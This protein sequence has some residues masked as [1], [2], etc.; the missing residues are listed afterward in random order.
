M[1]EKK[2]KEERRGERK[3]ERVPTVKKAIWPSDVSCCSFQRSKL[4]N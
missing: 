4:L 1:E 2:E 3:K